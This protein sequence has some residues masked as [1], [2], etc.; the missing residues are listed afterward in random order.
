MT[1]HLPADDDD[2]IVVEDLEEPAGGYVEPYVPIPS[3]NKYDRRASGAQ[4]ESPDSGK[5]AVR[6]EGAADPAAGDPEVRAEPAQ[7]HPKDSLV[8][9]SSADVVVPDPVASEYVEPYV[10]MP[11][12]DKY[13]RRASGAAT[14]PSQVSDTP[15][16][17]APLPTERIEVD[18]T[19]E[20]LPVP[21]AAVE[22]VY[23]RESRDLEAR[24]AAARATTAER[25]DP[26][27]NSEGLT[28]WQ[29]HS[30]NLPRLEEQSD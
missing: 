3:W 7:R 29:R 30:A 27:A 16:A 9:V 19:D 1:V 22:S 5:G 21:S 23:E 12:S 4:A 8:A 20:A 15:V 28:Y 6:P 17:E 25:P 13:D 14:E 11:S 10:P 26:F 18:L 2:S 24:A